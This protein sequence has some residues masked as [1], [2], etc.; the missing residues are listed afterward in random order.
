MAGTTITKLQTAGKKHSKK[1]K[2]GY[3]MIIENVQPLINI[4]K[5]KKENGLSG[6]NF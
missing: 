5:K 6:T 2:V 4:C 3:K 1:L